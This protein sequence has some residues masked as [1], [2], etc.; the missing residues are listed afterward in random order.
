MPVLNTPITTDDRGLKKVLGQKQPAILVLHDGTKDKPLEDTLK[1]AAKKADGELLVVRIDASENPNTY[2]KYGEPTLPA[3]VTMTPAF[4]GRKVKSEAE[5]VRPADIRAHID[6]LLYDNPLPEPVIAAAVNDS[7][8]A[9]PL[10]VTDQTFRKDVLKS[11][12][13]VLVDFWAP[14]CGPCRSIAPFVEQMAEEYKGDIRVVKL[15]TDE[16]QVMARR[17]QIQSIPTF[18]MFEGG[19]PIS[20][21]SGGNPGSIRAMIDRTLGR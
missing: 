14:W 13:P 16:N 19:Q 9:K 3:L 15:N 20:R 12:T 6:H 17:F 21:M 8:K 11:K 7:K 5:A 2:A 10:T 18:I 4:F 1:K